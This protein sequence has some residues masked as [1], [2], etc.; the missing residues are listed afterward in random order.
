MTYNVSSGTLNSTHSLMCDS[1]LALH[2][3]LSS[4]YCSA[5][6]QSDFRPHMS[7][8]SRV[9]RLCYS[10]LVGD[11]SIAISLSVCLSASVSLE[12]LDVHKILCADPLW[13]WLGPPLV[14]LRYVM[15]FQFYG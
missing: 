9:E 3:A 13:L 1:L 14:A 5:A 15:Y 7:T 11:R 6:E 2:T 10:A 4:D 12:P 8:S